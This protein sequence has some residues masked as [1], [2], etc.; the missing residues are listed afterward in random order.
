MHATANGAGLAG[1]ASINYR[2]H[3]FLQSWYKGTYNVLENVRKASPSEIVYV[4][5]K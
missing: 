3:G 5:T 4:S 2:N 1:F